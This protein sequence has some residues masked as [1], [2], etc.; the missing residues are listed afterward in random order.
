MPC[1]CRTDYEDSAYNRARA[2]AHVRYLAASKVLIHEGLFSWEAKD[3][4]RVTIILPDSEEF[5]D[6]E[7]DAR[8]KQVTARALCQSDCSHSAHA[9]KP[10]TCAF[11]FCLLRDREYQQAACAWLSAWRI[12]MILS[13]SS[14]SCSHAALCHLIYV[15]S[16]ALPLLL[17]CRKLLQ[18]SDPAQA[19][20]SALS[21]GLPA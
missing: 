11:V 9:Q 18:C 3:D 12:C 15:A 10:R 6:H 7:E 21:A 5:D 20:R 8:A 2:R 16:H 14:L 4:G 17:H 19:H 13:A 1:F